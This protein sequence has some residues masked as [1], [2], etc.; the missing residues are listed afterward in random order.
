M[1]RK[2][3]KVD[4]RS[5]YEFHSDDY[6]DGLVEDLIFIEQFDTANG[7]YKYNSL[8]YVEKW[9]EP[10]LLNLLKRN[11]FK[12]KRNILGSFEVILKNGLKVLIIKE[13]FRK[14][15]TRNYCRKPFFSFNTYSF[16][17]FKAKEWLS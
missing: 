13:R 10:R 7:H 11:K 16:S 12:F 9:N 17:F 2:I 4:K 1:G 3:Q 6:F 15:V 8:I 14:L 5:H